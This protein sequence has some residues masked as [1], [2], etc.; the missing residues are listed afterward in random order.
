MNVRLLPL[1]L[2]LSACVQSEQYGSYSQSSTLSYGSGQII[3]QQDQGQWQQSGYTPPQVNMHYHNGISHINVH[4]APPAPPP[5]TVYYYPV[6]P[7]PAPGTPYIRSERT[8]LPTCTRQHTVRHGTQ[9][10]IVEQPCL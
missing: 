3:T 9:T 2:L 8:Y 10:V 5:P 7:Q 6:Y 4:T 1:I